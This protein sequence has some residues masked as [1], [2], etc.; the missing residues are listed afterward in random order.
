MYTI[1]L[2]WKQNL[3]AFRFTSEQKNLL[4]LA[5]P[6]AAGC[7]LGRWRIR[8]G[9]RS[10]FGCPH[11]H[12]LQEIAIAELLRLPLEATATLLSILQILSDLFPLRSDAFL[13]SLQALNF[14]Q[15]RHVARR[16]WSSV[17]VRGWLNAIVYEC[18]KLIDRGL[19]IRLALGRNGTV[20]GGLTSSRAGGGSAGRIGGGA[21]ADVGG[22]HG[23][24]ELLLLPEPSPT[25]AE[26]LRVR[27]N[28]GVAVT[29]CEATS[30]AGNTDKASDRRSGDVTRTPRSRRNNAEN[31]LWKSITAPV[32]KMACN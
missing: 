17:G 27:P 32:G 8:W 24:A 13:F 2:W 20:A 5:T 22:R 15:Q 7:A 6:S 26:V 23:S 29:E 14:W 25:R 9:P 30:A 19:G 3:I 31:N 10:L 4:T 16:C 18:S 11:L 12:H 1:V 28:H 21:I